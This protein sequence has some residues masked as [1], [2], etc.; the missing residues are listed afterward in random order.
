MPPS[1]ARV[2]ITT[3]GEV[4]VVTLTRAERHN[5]MDFAMLDEVVRAQRAVRRLRDVRAVVLAGEGPSFCAGLDFKTALVSPVRAVL[6]YPQLFW[7]FRNRFQQWSLGWRDLGVPVIAAIH[8]N[9]F[10]A[11]LQLALGAD[12]RFCTPDASLSVMEA[13]WGLIPDMGGAVLLRELVRVD[14]AKELTLTGRVVTGA[15]AAELGLVTH[16]ADDPM[17]A[18]LALAAEIATRSPDAVA[19]GKQLLQ[20]AYG[21][22]QRSVERAERWWQRRLLGFAN[23]RIAVRRNQTGREQPYAR[24]RLGR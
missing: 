9:C 17:A 1:P 22:G 12:V 5:G 24:R 2:R 8:G 4:A 23:F 7:P 15:Q 13:K 20:Q 11:G 16:L 6:R 14:V 10:G 18:A 21:P 3:Q 19:A